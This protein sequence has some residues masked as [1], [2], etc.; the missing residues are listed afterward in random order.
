MAAAVPAIVLSGGPDAAPAWHDGERTGSGTIVWKARELLA[1]GEI[2][3]RQFIELIVS[4]ALGRALQHDGHRDDHEPLAEG[5]RLGSL[6][7]LCRHPR[8]LP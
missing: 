5:A 4:S 1:L 6:P 7:G 8:A 3:N 2:D